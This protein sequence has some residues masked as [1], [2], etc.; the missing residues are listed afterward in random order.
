MFAG[1]DD[2]FAPE[3]SAA[4]TADASPLADRLRPTRLDQVIGRT[5]SSAPMARSA[6]WWR[7]GGFR[8]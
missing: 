4:P 3:P 5:I 1:M 8:R 2:L 7:R 6:G